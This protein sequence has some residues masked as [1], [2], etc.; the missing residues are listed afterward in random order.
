MLRSASRAGSGRIDSVP[1]RM[2]WAQGAHWPAAP[3]TAA[4]SIEYRDSD[5]PCRGPGRLGPGTLGLGRP[6]LS[7]SDY[8]AG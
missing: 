8:R 2:L 1:S 3:G 5:A 7:D 6:I 4:L